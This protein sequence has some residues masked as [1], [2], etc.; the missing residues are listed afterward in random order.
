MVLPKRDAATRSAA[1]VIAN[2]GVPWHYLFVRETDIETA[3]D[4]WAALKKLAGA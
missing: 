2:T 4:S 1:H 3:K